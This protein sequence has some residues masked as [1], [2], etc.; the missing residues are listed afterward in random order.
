MPRS[1]PRPGEATQAAGGTASPRY[2]LIIVGAGP[3][4]SAAALA[5]LQANPRARV[6]LVDAASFP[7]DKACGDGIAPQALH[8][9]EALG[10][11]D[12][13]R[14]FEPVRRLRLRSPLGREVLAEP[15]EA[16]YCIPRKVFDARLVDAAVVR[17]A[18]LI[19]R[20]I[21]SMTVTSDS[22]E[23]APDLTAKV[24]IAADGANSAIRR[25]LKLPANPPQTCAIAMRGYA[26]RAPAP[27]TGAA[28][29][30]GEPEQLIEMVAAGWPAY[31]WSF[32]IGGPGHEGRA[33]VGFGMLRSSLAER[34]AEGSGRSALEGPLAA[35]LPEQPADPPTLRAHPLPLSTFRPRQPN[36]RVLLAGDAAS[37]IN[38]LTGEGIYYAVLSGK[39]AGE[40]ALSPGGAAAGAVYRRALRRELGL[41]LA[42]TS[43]LS[44]LSRSPELFDAGLALASRDTA[45]MDALVEVGLGRGTLPPALMWRLFRRAVKVGVASGVRR[46]V[47]TAVSQVHPTGGRLR[48]GKKQRSLHVRHRIDRQFRRRAG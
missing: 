17:G 10:V 48:G 11:P 20:R 33:N 31:A 16:A 22:V 40:A 1:D 37:L 39:L 13:A 9:L 4:G 19:Q 26:D 27:G 30:D 45:A 34:Q 46:L 28:G 35:L 3:A 6:A 24:V 14:D 44:R 21:R 42:T 29:T 18:E 8:V 25:L 15:P 23:L 41:H 47:R 38:P 7:R 32:P 36:G 12:A 2:D 5:A 43:V